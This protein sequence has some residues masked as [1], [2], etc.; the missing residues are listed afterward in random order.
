MEVKIGIAQLPKEIIIDAQETADEIITQLKNVL[1]AENGLLTL[2]DS[3]G[4][5]VVAVAARIGYLEFGQEHA[6]PVGFGALA[7]A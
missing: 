5:R 1:G 7:A 6:R 3:K 2:T 4:R